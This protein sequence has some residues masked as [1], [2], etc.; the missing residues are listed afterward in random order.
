MISNSRFLDTRPRSVKSK[1]SLVLQSS[2]ASL[3]L[4]AHQS[5]PG[6]PAAAT[7]IVDQSFAEIVE[8]GGGNESLNSRGGRGATRSHLLSQI[9]NLYLYNPFI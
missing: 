1:S 8:G 2:L 7:V 9:Q 3:V 4:S 6:P 5:P